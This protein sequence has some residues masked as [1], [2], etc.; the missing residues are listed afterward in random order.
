MAAATLD[1]AYVDHPRIAAE[2]QASLIRLSQQA[3]SQSEAGWAV[4]A[5]KASVL[6]GI[7]FASGIEDFVWEDS[8][9]VPNREPPSATLSR[10]QADAAVVVE[11]MTDPKRSLDVQGPSLV[12]GEASREDAARCDGALLQAISVAVFYYLGRFASVELEGLGVR[13]C[14]KWF[15]DGTASRRG[16]HAP[17]TSLEAGGCDA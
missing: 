15:L 11:A 9:R 10:V 14:A 17:P 3:S 1:P 2:A 8:A 12:I 7:F 4:E 6:G 13:S 16:R 5:V